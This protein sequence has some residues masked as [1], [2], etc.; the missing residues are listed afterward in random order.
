MRKFNGNRNL[1]GSYLKQK[2]LEKNYNRSD[3][4]RKLQLIGLNISVDDIYRIETNRIFLKD[5]ELVA[6]SIV[7][8]ID[9]NDLKEFYN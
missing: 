5:F 2:R 1:S 6:F 3:L 4:A 9:L 8:N 7:L